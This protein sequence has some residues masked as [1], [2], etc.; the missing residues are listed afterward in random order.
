M[1]TEVDE[2]TPTEPGQPGPAPT[3]ITGGQPRRPRR[4][5][6]IAFVAVTVVIGG[7]LIAVAASGGDSDPDPDPVPPAADAEVLE[8]T[9]GADDPLA[10]CLAF[11]VA[12]LS[13]MSPA[14]AGTAIAVSDDTVTL[15]VDRW[16][17]GGTAPTVV[18]RTTPGMEA[19]IGGIA[20]DVGQQYL[21]TAADGTVNFCGYSGAATPELTAAFDQAFGA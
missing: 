2:L 13:D 15:G 14:F 3:T 17:A 1:N 18:L 5:M 9:L 21:I 6:L 16:Y 7:V 11:E 12:T 20:F 19:L 8:L 4:S 10:S